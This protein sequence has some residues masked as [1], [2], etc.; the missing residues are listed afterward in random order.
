MRTITCLYRLRSAVAILFLAFLPLTVF[1]APYEGMESTFTQPDGTN[2]TLRFFGD[3][4]YTR[5]ETVD[6][7]AVIFDSEKSCYFYAQLSPGGDNFVSTGKEVGKF[8]P[9]KLGLKKGLKINTKSRAAKIRKRFKEIDAVVKQSEKWENLKQAARNFRA[10]QRKLKQNKKAG[11]TGFAIPMGTLM[12]DS[13]TATTNNK[14]LL[15]NSDS[16]SP[17]QAPPN[18]T[19]TGDVVGLTIL[20]DFSDEVA[21]VSQVDVDNF[22]NEP[23][24][25]NWG[26]SGSI[27]DYYKVQSSGKLRYTNSVTYYVRVPQPKT[28]Y[29]DT[30]LGSG[31]CG[32]R[33]LSDALDVLIADSFDFSSCSTKSGGNIRAC[34]ILFAGSTSGVWAKGLWP[35]RWVLSPKK[36]LGNG[37][38]VYD[39]QITNIGTELKIGTFCHENGH[40]LL[41]YPD[42]YDYGHDSNGLGKYTLMASGNHYYPT[43]PIN[44]HGYLKWHSGW[45]E[46]IELSTMPTPIRL[47]ARVDSDTV[48][49]YT[50]TADND[51][52]FMITNRGRFG[53]EANS[54]IPD[55]GLFITHNDENGNRDA[56]DMTEN[57]HYECSLE[58]ADGDFDLEQDRN[59]GDD[60][61]LFHAAGEGPATSFDDSTVPNAKWWAGA[62]GTPA[63]GTISGLNIHSI[64]EA[65]YTMTFIYGAG[66]P[67]GAPSI[68][69]D[70]AVIDVRCNFGENALSEIFSIFNAG[71]GT[72]NYT[73][74][75]DQNW[76]SCD[77][78][79]GAVVD[80]AEN[81]GID[82]QTDTLA[83][84]NYSATISIA[85]SVASNS[86]RTITVNLVVTP[87]PTISLNSNTI[88]KTL[89]SG[90]TTNA[91]FSI[92]NTGGSVLRYSLSA[93]EDWI[94][95]GTLSGTTIN[96]VDEI[97]LVL[98]AK[99]IASGV[100]TGIITI[101]DPLS[102]NHSQ[103]VNVTMNVNPGVDIILSA[104]QGGGKL[105]ADTDYTIKWDTSN[106]LTG[107]IKIELLKSGAVNSTITASTNNTGA[108][109]W[110]ISANQ[111]TATDYKIR[112]SSVNDA[113][114][115]DESDADFEIIPL[116]NLITLPYSE[117]FENDFGD[118]TQLTSDDMDWTK[119]KGGTPSSNT[120]PANAKEGEYYI[121]TEA[122]NPNNPAKSAV[123]QTAL[124]LRTATNPIMTFWY[125]MHG[126]QM[127]TLKLE[128]TKDLSAFET[129]FEKS[130]DQ[131][132]KWLKGEINLTK[133]AGSVI[134]LR[135][136]GTTGSG[137]LS[138]IS[139]DDIS[140]E[141]QAPPA[142][143]TLTV[144]NGSGDGT[145]AAGAS[146]PVAA[147]IPTGQIFDKWLGGGQSI[148]DA[149]SANTTVTMPANDL[150]IT[151][152]FKQGGVNHPPVANNDSYTVQSGQAFSVNTASGILSNDV[153][154]D[155]DSLISGIVNLPS[156]GT[157]NLLS[158]G[159]FSYTSNSGYVGLD[160][161]T[162]QAD[163]GSLKSNTAA[164]TLTVT[165][166]SASP[167][168]VGDKYD[169]PQDVTTVIS[170]A[171]GV[172]ANDLN[173]SGESV[174]LLSNPSKG[175]LTL[176]PDGSFQYIPIKDFSG[177]DQFTYQIDGVNPQTTAVVV[178]N[179]IPVKIT[180]DSILT[181][182]S[183]DLATQLG[184]AAFA[185]PPKL[186]GVFDNGKKAAMKKVKTST[187]TEFSGIWRKRFTLYDKKALK[188]GYKK[189]FQSAP[190]Q[191]AKIT[192]RVKGVTD[193]K[194]KIDAPVQT[195]LLVPP[196]ITAIED[197]NG[198]PITSAAPGDT[199]VITGKYFG[200]R[201]PKVGFEIDGKLYKCKIDSKSYIYANSKGKMVIMNSLTAESYIKVILPTKH[202]VTGTYPLILNNGIGIATDSE[203][204]T[205]L[206]TFTIR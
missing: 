71:G 167:S 183:L 85:D 159:S 147:T 168:A 140:I 110:H 1:S 44:I 57:A 129:L 60:T 137:Y 56:Q 196:V 132:D 178:L 134:T 3:E 150:S 41:G 63:S 55:S 83:P 59:T 34:N 81:I 117:S 163:D 77:P 192:I 73:I 8:D 50:N 82:F 84:G 49:K 9:A 171:K 143:Y 54:G 11:K 25:K 13:P 162:Y 4:F 19:L 27:Y 31:T 133:Y 96:E 194:V 179:V 36:D 142:T 46:A 145:Y 185:K 113:T 197:L 166:G 201:K 103:I 124:D 160:K 61:D 75:D 69:V 109:L 40:M 135:F 130:N 88:N 79:N 6:G 152:T 136:T 16:D 170:V 78:A 42:Y 156:H 52:Y 58:Q 158:D 47:A 139:L 89:D 21:T 70:V 188:Q 91:S 181:Y 67:T 72:L 119:I 108:F 146:V 144:N 204:S 43:N 203:G 100:H 138:D 92:T 68:G 5:T 74:T 65:D 20:V 107:N 101:S 176:E 112:I 105:Y 33:L 23:G 24:F 202:L 97:P 180:R 99:G 120:G 53:W 125:H 45:V 189:Y 195:V 111:S 22:C 190:S 66:N 104:P 161:F 123:L 86:P 64:S 17:D 26:N 115:N 14:S 80:T 155:G 10:F 164:V 128:V 205:V 93:S 12:P 154:P 106:S 102:T 141:S 94:E 153:D 37:K 122:S 206:P 127:G 174:S 126:T 118:W 32:R 157:L 165:A 151:A 116:S 29:N 172:L 175:T 90:T 114:M 182:K 15:Q 87:A 98:N 7:Y 191:S 76:L 2:L 62:D 177:V 35:H 198:N 199:I 18:F 149:N 186:Y 131:G 184:G 28:Y 38:Y 39:Y 121:Y 173:A 148:A 95:L 48:Y 169:I 193:T 30:S 200:N 187:V 51:E